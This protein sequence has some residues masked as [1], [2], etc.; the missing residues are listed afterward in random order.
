MSRKVII[1]A[2]GLVAG[3]VYSPGILAGKLLFVSGHTGSDPVTREIRHGIQEQTRQALENIRGVLDAAGA[4]LAD[5][6]KI[7][8]HMVDMARDFAPMNEVFKE[9]F[10]SEPPARCTV[11]VSHL[12]R[13]GLLLEIEAT[14]VLAA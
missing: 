6:A 1:P 9:Y 11:G 14:A 10:P 8:I 5:V 4:S 3:R 12:A 7:N 2:T 13:P